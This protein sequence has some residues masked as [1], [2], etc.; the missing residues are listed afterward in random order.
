MRI[1]LLTA[2]SLTCCLVHSQ[3]SDPCEK[4]LPSSLR[5]ILPAKFPGYRL[6]RVTDYLKEDIDQHKKDHNGSPCIGLALADVDGDGFLDFAFFLTDST[7]HTI[8]V[9]ARNPSGNTWQISTL[10]DFGKNGPGRS[11]VEFLKA[12]SYQDLFDSSEEG[13]SDFTPE[14]GRVRKFKARRP[15]FMAG[16]I[17][18]SGIAFFFTG[19]QWV[20]L[21]LSD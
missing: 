7:K 20:H 16:T 2:L 17:E 10:Y 14:P 18:S 1:L 19:K 6:A 5:E 8:L 15:G 12:G 9:C 4:K 11:Y 13:P 21:W 3:A